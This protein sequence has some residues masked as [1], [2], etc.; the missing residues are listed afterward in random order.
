MKEKGRAN[1]MMM[2]EEEG[3]GNLPSG[4]LSPRRIEAI[5]TAFHTFFENAR[6]EGK[7][8]DPSTYGSY[9]RLYEIALK[10]RNA[11]DINEVVEEERIESPP[12]NDNSFDNGNY[13][14]EEQRESSEV[15]EQNL[16]IAPQET[17]FD[18][19]MLSDDEE[20]QPPSSSPERR[21]GRRKRTIEY[22]ECTSTS[23]THNF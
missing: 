10:R 13:E 12:F 21:L 4:L 9:D 14:V 6:K 15:V 8:R 1:E 17:E 16:P 23:L 19:T 7:I 5:D 3:D 22:V 2:M 11:K 18:D 20:Y